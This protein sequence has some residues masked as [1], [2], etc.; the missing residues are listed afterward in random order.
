MREENHQNEGDYSDNPP[1]KY[2]YELENLP[3]YKSSVWTGADGISNKSRVT[4]I[5]YLY[6]I[7]MHIDDNPLDDNPINIKQFNESVIA[8]TLAVYILDT[9]C[10]I[11]NVKEENFLV[12]A[13]CCLRIAKYSASQ[14]GLGLDEVENLS[15]G[16]TTFKQ[17]NETSNDILKAIGGLIIRPIPQLFFHPQQ[18]NNPIVNQLIYLSL[19]TKLCTSQKAST[20][21]KTIKYLLYGSEKF[22]NEMDDICIGISKNFGKD[23]TLEG[24]Q[25]TISSVTGY[26]Y[27]NTCPN[28]H[29]IIVPMKKHKSIP[30]E[31]DIITQNSYKTVNVIGEGISG[32]VYK[33]NRGK[34]PLAAKYQNNSYLEEIA[35]LSLLRNS[36]YIVKLKGILPDVR[37]NE[38]GEDTPG[39]FLFFELGDINLKQSITDRYFNSQSNILRC[40]KDIMM[41]LKECHYHDIIHCDI[42]PENI[43]WFE[44]E[45]RWKLIDFGLS[46]EMSA[47]KIKVK[48]VE[49]LPYRAPEVI[50]TDGIYDTKID[51]W[52]AGCVL[53]EMITGIKFV[54]SL[55]QTEKAF[56][57]FMCFTLG[58]PTKESWPGLENVK[59]NTLDSVPTYG[60]KNP[61]PFIHIKLGVG[62]DNIDLCKALLIKILVMYPGA[63]PSAEHIVRCLEILKL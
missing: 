60:W 38:D 55:E 7:S 31:L 30:K 42:K 15:N 50:I 22:D 23:S 46:T 3:E 57:K 8:L 18:L 61:D 63:R 19:F 9:Y 37:K 45:K 2:L 35:I 44:K 40:F 4:M 16:R 26:A 27:K 49:T 6:R 14:Y 48:T 5:D 24:L 53:Y 13:L 1:T 20:V 62:N 34:E 54:R 39:S 47:F 17:A 12:V 32:D 58:K 43:V 56:L 52:A 59:N 21:A 33:I 28:L 11:R 29:K 36:N 25:R 41:G 51:I 10:S